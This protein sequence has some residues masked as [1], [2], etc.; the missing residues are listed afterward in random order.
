M[1]RKLTRGALLGV[2]VIAGTSWLGLP[3][4]RAQFP[5]FYGGEVLTPF[6]NRNSDG[7]YRTAPPRRS[8]TPRPRYNTTP[9]ARARY[10]Y[11]APAPR[12]DYAQPP[13]YFRAHNGYVYSR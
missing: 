2:L 4:T 6:G 5:I 1:D 8:P 12:Y 3:P 7:S 13:V 9:P 11:Y 10:N